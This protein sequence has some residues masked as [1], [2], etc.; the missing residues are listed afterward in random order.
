M[1]DKTKQEGIQKLDADELEQAAGGILLFD[2]LQAARSIKKSRKPGAGSVKKEGI[3]T[4]VIDGFSDRVDQVKER[5][6][7]F[8]KG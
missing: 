4:G 1:E 7:K 5:L 2:A 6:D 8:G 3:L